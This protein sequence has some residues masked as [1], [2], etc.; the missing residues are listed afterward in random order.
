M[1]RVTLRA[2]SLIAF[3]TVLI[4]G[5]VIFAAYVRLGAEAF[6]LAADEWPKWLL[7]PLVTQICLYYT[8]LYDLRVISDRRELFVRAVHALGATSFLLAALYLWFPDLVIGRGVFILAALCVITL[9]LGWRVVFE[10]ANRHVAPRERL[11]LVGTNEAAVSLARELYERR[12]LGVE[13]VGFI[14]PDP[15]PRRRAGAQ[16]RRRRHD[17]RHPD[18]RARAR[19]RSGG[20]QP[21]GR[22]RQAADGQAARDAAR[23]RGVRSP[24]VRVRGVHREDR[25]RE[26]ASELADLLA[27]LPEGAPPPGEQADGRSRWPPRSG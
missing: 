24:G 12:N 21:G 23:R 16:P 22:P 1:G 27:G 20:R 14:D 7:I 25:R 8:D 13:I 26:P 15:G 3:E 6:S 18:R 5:A 9:V 17:R 19:R 2:G 11:L 4:C 10:W